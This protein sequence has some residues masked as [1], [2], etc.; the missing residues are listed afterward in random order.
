MVDLDTSALFRAS[1]NIPSVEV[2]PA[3]WIVTEAA[4]IVDIDL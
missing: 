1:K 4:C 2:C 3:E